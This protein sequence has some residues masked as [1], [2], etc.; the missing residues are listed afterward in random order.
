MEKFAI[1]VGTV[2][3]KLVV[4]DGPNADVEAQAQALRTLTDASGKR[5]GKGKG[6]V[7]DAV[8]LHSS[9]GVFKKRKNIK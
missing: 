8:I 7:T 5:P 1:T 4:L 3:G 6:T 9:K 2:D